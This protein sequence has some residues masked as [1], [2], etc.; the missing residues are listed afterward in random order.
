MPTPIPITLER[1]PANV[2]PW[3]AQTVRTWLMARVREEV[4]LNGQPR[5]QIILVADGFI[6]TFNLALMAEMD[7]GASAGATFQALSDRPK[8]ERRFVLMQMKGEDEET[9]EARRFAVLFEEVDDIVERKRL[10]WYA[11]LEFTTDPTS[12]IGL[13][14]AQWAV[15]DEVRATGET[16][17][18]AHLWP[19]LREF[20]APPPGS[21]AAAVLPPRI[22]APDI[23]VAADRLPDGL[24]PP[25][26]ARQ[27]V[28][29]AGQ[30][31]AN[32]L[33]TAEVTGTVVVRIAGNAWEMWVLG[34]PMPTELEDMVRYIANVRQPAADGVA[35]AQ[36]VIRPRDEP[37][38]VGM[39][40]IGELGGEFC[41]TWGP[42]E[43]L[44]G[45]KGPKR[46]SRIAW[47][48]PMPVS[49]RGLW[50]G[51]DP[52]VLFELGP[53]GPEA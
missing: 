7:S 9:N 20:A 45:P 25:V 23:Q 10:W 43:Y 39:Q 53:L 35:L 46:I 5:S 15:A 21:R 16:D 26:N 44:Q 42:L 3:D 22:L 2:D 32:D 40:V 37:P 34:G 38:V 24:A 6:E 51:I 33:L 30:L 31:A 13:P 12:G 52:M 49:E 14:A 48:G 17:N 36:I 4:K 18:P 19:F 11:T 50:L 28:Q 29:F 8:I 41:E 27:M 47:R 1:S